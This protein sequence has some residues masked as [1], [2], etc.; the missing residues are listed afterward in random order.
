M[1]AIVLNQGLQRIGINMSAVGT[2]LGTSLSTAR[3]FQTMAV[4][5][6]TGG[7]GFPR[8]FAAGDVACSSD[9]TAGGTAPTSSYDALLDATPTR[10]AQTTSHVMTIPTGSGNFLIVRVS[11]HDDTATNTT[12]TSATLAAGLDGNSIS[13]SSSFTLKIT[14]NLL[15]TSV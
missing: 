4:D 15:Y 7:A 9:G 12:G 13:K 3:W 10:S 1:T 8:N 6:N 5:T 11:L 14:L 2:T